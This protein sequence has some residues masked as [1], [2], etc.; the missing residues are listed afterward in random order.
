MEIIGDTIRVTNADSAILYIDGETTFREPDPQASCVAKLLSSRSAA[1]ADIRAAHI[2][3]YF[4]LFS[5]V[6]LQISCKTSPSSIG[7][8]TDERMAQAR[9]GQTDLALIILY[10]QFGRYLLIAS[11]RPGYK[12]LPANLQGIWNESMNP[13][14]GSKFTLNV[15]AE[16]NYWHAETTN[17]SEC[18]VPFFDFLKRLKKNGEVTARVMYGCRGWVAHHNSDIWAD[19][20]PQ[21]RW[22]PSTLW[23]LGGA[24]ASTHIWEHYRFTGDM[25]FLQDM[26]GVLKG[27]VQFFLDFLVEKD[28]YLVTNPSLS[29]ENKYRLSNGE[30][31]SMCIGPTMDSGILFKLFTD[32]ISSAQLLK[33]PEDKDMVDKV[34]SYRSRLPPLRIGRHGQILE[35][36]QDY[37][38]VEPGHRHISHLWALFPGSQI[39][40]RQPDLVNAC[41]KTL[42][43]RAAYGGGHT[44]W[45]RAWMIASWARL[46]SGEEAARHIIELLRSSTFDSLL[47][48]HPPFQ[49]DGNFGA[50]AAITEMIVQSHND[51]IFFLPALPHFWSEG[52]CVGIRARGGFEVSLKWA[53]SRALFGQVRSLHGN[54]CVLSAKQDFTVLRCGLELASFSA[55]SGLPVSFTTQAGDDFEVYF[56]NQAS[57]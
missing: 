1:Y 39:T 44:G 27:A 28:C 56:V 21:D 13:T 31:G 5:R 55:A 45:S 26:Y 29:P 33:V 40:S 54:T 42:E 41:K 48:N 25:N 35:W 32:F 52:S 6:T 43:R 3:D 51:E 46:G 22:L 34:K 24:W 10:F 17:L 19:T 37:E 49:I 4:S 23:C 57:V 8:P 9:L 16:M 30:E 15:N 7:I 18:H 14:W 2:S 12:A 47:D 50:T 11:S 20:A 36:L 38:E 53:E